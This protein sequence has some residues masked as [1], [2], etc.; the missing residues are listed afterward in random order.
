MTIK[1]LK[2][3]AGILACIA[4]VTIIVALVVL[5]P[6]VKFSRP[7]IETLSAQANTAY[8]NWFT[9]N[10]LNRNDIFVS[11]DFLPLIEQGEF[12]RTDNLYFNGLPVPNFLRNRRLTSNAH[13]PNKTMMYITHR[14]VHGDSYYFVY[15]FSYGFEYP[16]GTTPYELWEM[17]LLYFDYLQKLLESV[18]IEDVAMSLTLVFTDIFQELRM[19]I[20]GLMQYSGINMYISLTL[21]SPIFVEIEKY[22]DPI[23][24]YDI[25]CEWVNG[26]NG[27]DFI[28]FMIE[29]GINRRAATITVIDEF[30]AI[31]EGEDSVMH[32]SQM[33]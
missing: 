13:L 14:N 24:A 20:D 1:S 26:V 10:N 27:M 17:R 5:T 4:T 12:A 25:L 2:I 30:T 32:F 28:V 11:S 15:G 33:E 7:T 6:A 16:A 9:T 22:P 19:F 8:G 31:I 18:G 29:N 23:S 21:I 3:F